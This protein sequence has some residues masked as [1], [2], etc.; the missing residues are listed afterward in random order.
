MDIQTKCS[1]NANEI[2]SAQ[3]L[4]LNELSNAGSLMCYRILLEWGYF[5]ALFNPMKLL[6]MRSSL[7]LSIFL[8]KIT[9]ILLFY[10]F[11][12]AKVSKKKVHSDYMLLHCLYWLFHD[13]GSYHIKQ[14][15]WFA[16][17]ICSALICSVLQGP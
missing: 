5:V 2:W 17:Q 13:G 9:I 8:T 15:H 7:D 1:S 14:G 12:G 3:Q 16:L 6:K 4:M 10:L 11:R